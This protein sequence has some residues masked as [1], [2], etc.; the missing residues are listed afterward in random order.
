MAAGAGGGGGGVGA[1]GGGGG[2]GGAGAAGAGGRKLAVGLQDRSD[3][4]AAA[5]EAGI[6]LV[7]AGSGAT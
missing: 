4:G 3:C 6:T 7:P 1:P 5:V 2:G